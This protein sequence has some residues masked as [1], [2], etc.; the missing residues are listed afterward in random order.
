VR[1]TTSALA[2]AVTLLLAAAPAPG[3]AADP[4]DAADRTFSVSPGSTLS[5][6]LVHKLHAVVGTSSAV[7]GRARLLPDG[8]LQVAVRSR[9]EAFDSGNGN[10]DEHMLE[11]T[12]AARFPYVSVKAVGPFRAPASYPATVEI[13]LEGELTFHGRS[14][15]VAF[16]V[17]VR[18]AGPSS[19]IADAS[20]PVSLDAYG[21]ERP[22]L[23]FVKVDDRIDVAAHLVLEAEARTGATPPPRADLPSAPRPRS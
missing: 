10:R 12:E 1:A 18:L 5:Y 2:V 3:R 4:P 9:V 7:E 20:F 21:V 14:R 6:H 13:P 23:F 19:A 15:P 17:T 11:A 22:S 16:P 8:T